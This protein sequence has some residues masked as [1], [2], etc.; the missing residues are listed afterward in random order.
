MSPGL[1]HPKRFH[2]AVALRNEMLLRTLPAAP[3]ATG[4]SSVR[5]SFFQAW[6]VFAVHMQSGSSSSLESV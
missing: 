3:R 1:L 6:A 4:V 2:A 5:A